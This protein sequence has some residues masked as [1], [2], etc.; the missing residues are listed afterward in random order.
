MF[1]QL[2]FFKNLHQGTCLKTPVRT[3][4]AKRNA[5]STAQVSSDGFHRLPLFNTSTSVVMDILL[6]I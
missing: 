4:S 5:T 3:S 1:R 6:T 2:H